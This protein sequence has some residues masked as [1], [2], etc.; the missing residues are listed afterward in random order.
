MSSVPDVT[1]VVE[2]SLSGTAVFGPLASGTSF[3]EQAGQ[4]SIRFWITN[5]ESTSVVVNTVALS[6]VPRRSSMPSPSRSTSK[7]VPAAPNSGTS[8]R[9]TISFYGILRRQP[10]PS[11]CGAAA[12]AIRKRLRCR[13]TPTPIR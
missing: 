1:V 3:G 5:H 12:S 13:S 6:F 7:L 2:P 11:A 4:L 8:P 9:R 10:L